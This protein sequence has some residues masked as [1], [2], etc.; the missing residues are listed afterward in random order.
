MQ[1][2]ESIGLELF[3]VTAGRLVTVR[4]EDGVWSGGMEIEYLNVIQG[5]WARVEGGME[6]TTEVENSGN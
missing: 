4:T 2:E 1:E 6:E 5:L 3:I